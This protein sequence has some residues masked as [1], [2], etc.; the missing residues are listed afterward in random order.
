[1]GN[2][3]KLT[4]TDG[5]CSVLV[6]MLLMS[7]LFFVFFKYNLYLTDNTSSKSRDSLADNISN[8]FKNELDKAYHALE[9]FDSEY[10]CVNDD[11]IN[12]GKDTLR[13]KTGKINEAEKKQLNGIAKNIFVQQV[14]WLDKSGKE[15]NNWTRDTAYVPHSNFGSREYFRRIVNNKT[16]KINSDE[17]YL[18]QVISRTSGEFTSVIARKPSDHNIAVVAMTFTAKSLDHVVMPDGYQFAIIDRK[19]TV[20]YHSLTDRNL[21]ENLKKELADSTELIS[22]IEAKS[23]TSFKEEYYGKSN[24]IKI[25]P[26]EDLPYY[27]VVFED[28]EYNDTRD[29]EAYAFT[30]SMLGFLLI[31]LITQFSIVFFA[32]SKKSFFKK[33]LFETSWVGPKKIF[34][35]HYNLAIIINL[36]IIALLIYYFDLSSFLKYLYIVLFSVTFIALFTNGIFAGYYKKANHYNLRFKMFA[37]FWLLVFVVVIDFAAYHMLEWDNFKS[38][39]SYEIILSVICGGMT[40]ACVMVKSWWPELLGKAYDF[41]NAINFPWTYT[42][43]FSLMATTRLVVTSGIP[44]AF[45]FIYSFNYEQNLDTRYKQ[46]HFARALNQKLSNAI[47]KPGGLTPDLL[48]A[49]AIYPDSTFI[50]TIGQSKNGINLT[51]KKEDFLTVQLLSLFRLQE[52]D[53]AV[54]S[55]NMNLAS[56]DGKAFFNSLTHEQTGND[57]TTQTFY[58]IASDNYIALSSAKNVYYL[59]HKGLLV[60]L[61]IVL[62][63]G[64]YYMIHNIIRKLF[65]LGLPLQD[66]WKEMDKKILLDNELN[67]LLLIV[68]PPGSGKLHKLKEKINEGEMEGHDG[69]KLIYNEKDPSMNNVFI[70]DMIRIPAKNGEYNNWRK[71]KEEALKKTNAL[72][73][74]NHFEYN[75]KDPGTNSTKLDFLESLML[76]GVSK[77]MIIS[78]VHP[79][80][81]LDSFDEEQNNIKPGSQSDDAKGG[82][83]S[84]SIPISELER[85]HVLLGHFRIV[86]ESLESENCEDEDILRESIKEETQ[87]THYLND[88]RGE[89]LNTIPFLNNQGVGL[90]TDSLIF[91]LQL[92]SHYF[93]TYIWQSLTKEEKFLLYDL[94]EDGLV[95]PFDDYNLSMLIYKGLITREKGTLT[96]FNKGFRNYIL[97][98][99]GNSEV[100][101]IKAQVKDNGNWGNL[102]TPLNLAILAILVF[103]IASQQE[104]YTKIITYI[105]ALGAGV[106]AVLRVFSLVGSSKS[107]QKTE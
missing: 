6:S 65:A 24:Y 49:E 107:T 77:V 28:Q 12:L 80:T 79:L 55:S 66:G 35:K 36:T 81:F 85:W 57:T 89:A 103:L 29:T 54:K 33:Q 64:F 62:V 41:K 46:Y 61:L 21:N 91:K 53:V 60:P 88:I 10:A 4:I 34:H 51:Y 27:I 78:T 58:K 38:L 48:H 18:A 102:K 92:S 69:N 8:S 14:Y 68:G 56:V 44:V 72:V 98:A 40:L 31:F 16:Y 17:F 94:A 96:L 83:Q 93:Y 74:V 1:M 99:I 90:P 3:D 87:Y 45:F 73:I 26:L 23:D 30:V 101:R 97:T 59:S 82:Q 52:N 7:L 42:H 43:S 50:H 20:L 37:I 32:S 84:N 5:L 75:I 105:T 11:I 106:P 86:V 15:L 63:I 13:S 2:K 39:L 71:H 47:N 22:C 95:N 100:E 76:Q 9:K 104:A 19:G 25:K 70:A 67:S